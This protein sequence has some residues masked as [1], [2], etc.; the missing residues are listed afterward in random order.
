MANNWEFKGKEKIKMFYIP[1]PQI[2]SPHK[3]FIWKMKFHELIYGD[4]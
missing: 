2:I 4:F 3:K 1:Y